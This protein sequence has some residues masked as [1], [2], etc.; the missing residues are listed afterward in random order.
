ML[1]LEQTHYLFFRTTLADLFH[2]ICP[3]DDWK[4]AL[5]PVLV[6]RDFARMAEGRVIAQRQSDAPTESTPVGN[7]RTEIQLTVDVLSVNLQ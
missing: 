5:K 4:E 2:M 7:G 3:E 6:T 1:A